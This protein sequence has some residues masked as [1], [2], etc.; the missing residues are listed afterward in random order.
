[1]SEEVS[2]KKRRSIAL[3]NNFS[4]HTCESFST[5]VLTSA[6]TKRKLGELGEIDQYVFG[7]VP[8]HVNG[9]DEM[10]SIVGGDSAVLVKYQLTE[11]SMNKGVLSR[12]R[13]EKVRLRIKKY[14][15]E[16]ENKAVPKDIINAYRKECGEEAE[17]ELIKA[18]KF[19]YQDTEI[20]VLIVR[21]NVHKN[22]VLIEHFLSKSA[23]RKLVYDHLTE[24]GVVGLAPMFT[25]RGSIACL[26]QLQT[27]PDILAENEVPLKG[28]SGQN[29]TAV[30]GKKA[31]LM[32]KKEK[33]FAEFRNQETQSNDL[34]NSN[35]E[36]GKEVLGLQLVL[37]NHYFFLDEDGLV[38]NVMYENAEEKA[39][40]V[41]TDEKGDPKGET[42]DVNQELLTTSYGLCGVANLIY[43]LSLI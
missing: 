42:R 16:N 12:L 35:I 19:G 10:Y 36:S 27:D 7:Y 40:P 28:A 23:L 21:D 5:D 17:K 24:A 6:P 29:K 1:M 33:W 13:S 15:D 22:Y 32:D 37:D 41:T 43:K 8:V 26:T 18:K 11:R 39:A 9:E 34:I 3:L 30:L 25:G 4:I 20:R 31:T 14:K 38:R 2:K